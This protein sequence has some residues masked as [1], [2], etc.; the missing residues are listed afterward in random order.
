MNQTCY[1]KNFHIAPQI[2]ILSFVDDADAPATELLDEAVMRDGLT[3][4]G[5]ARELRQQY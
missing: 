4:H 5:R 3:D 1:T 2:H